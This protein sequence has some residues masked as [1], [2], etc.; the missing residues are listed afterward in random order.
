MIHHDRVKAVLLNH[1][2]LDEKTIDDLITKAKRRNL[3]ILS[4]LVSQNKVSEQDLYTLISEDFHV[5]FINLESTT[6][7]QIVL[8]LLP[9]QL[10]QTHR[11]AIFDY[12]DEQHLVKIAS[13]DPDDL[14]MVDFIR[15]KTGYNTE[16]Y[17]T[18]PASID[19]IIQQYNRHI[20]KEFES[21]QKPLEGGGQMSAA[22]VDKDIP[23]IKIFDTLLDYAIF[24]NASD[25][26][27]EPTDKHIIV[28]FRIDGVLK[29]VMTLPKA[30]QSGLLARI[31]ILAHLKIDEH[32]LPQDGR[33]TIATEQAKVSVRVSILPVYDGEKV[34]MRLLKESQN[35]LTLEQLGFNERALATVKRHI[36]KPHGMLLATGP[37]GS[38]K[39]TTLYTMMSILNTPDVNISTVEDPI[40][41]RMARI[42]Q[43]QVN[44]K[45]GFTFAGGLRSLLRQDPNI[46]MVG[47]IRDNETAQIASHAAMTGHLVLSTLH[48]NDSV[49]SAFRLSEMGVPNFLIASTVN[50]I[51]AQRLVRKICTDCI[52]SYKLSKETMEDIAKQ[53]NMDDVLRGLEMLGEYVPEQGSLH[54]INFYRGA[55]CVKCGDSGYKGR[56]GIYE[57]FE[58]T[59]AASKAILHQSS[60]TELLEIAV[61]DGMI[62]MVQDGFVKAKRGITTIEE[63]LRVTKE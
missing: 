20:E 32:R 17:L 58:M 28:R 63:I 56:M 18:T 61:K 43:S 26:H 11:V 27:V 31:K 21:F 9:Q 62:T 49:S 55:G 47:E 1:H 39:T 7:P 30:V 2:I 60:K 52:V 24:Q 23:I 40:E 34:V 46:I 33:I 5:P 16:V 10:V 41:Y 44:P 54:E 8:D 57:V 19:H 6:L 51:M 59:E 12:N 14:Q 25:V 35:V 48:T 45:I 37:T 53:Y 42:N 36:T 50:I 13:T 15:K 22:Q 29:D 38:G 4:Y 3:D